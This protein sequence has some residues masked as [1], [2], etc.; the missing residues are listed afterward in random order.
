MVGEVE[1]GTTVG[2]R[3]KRLVGLRVGPDG[4]DVGVA[5]GSVVG[6]AE[7]ELVGRKVGAQVGDVEGVPV[8]GV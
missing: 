5:D 2:R 7:G 3:D 1:V 6:I 8:V 4:L